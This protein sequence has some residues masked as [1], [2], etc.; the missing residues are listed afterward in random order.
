MRPARENYKFIGNYRKTNAIKI[1][2]MTITN[3]KTFWLPL[4]IVLD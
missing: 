4:A 1:G 2:D 3:F